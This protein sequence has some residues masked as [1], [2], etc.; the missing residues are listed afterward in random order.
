MIS[1]SLLGGRKV[2]YCDATLLAPEEVTTL[3][4]VRTLAQD[5][6]DN[7]HLVDSDFWRGRFVFFTNTI[8]FDHNTTYIVT[9]S[10]GVRPIDGNL[11]LS[12]DLSIDFTTAPKFKFTVS[13]TEHTIKLMFTQPLPE[14][15]LRDGLISMEVQD[16][17]FFPFG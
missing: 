10:S 16:S 11:P 12:H 2:K 6:M 9:F 4:A 7:S 17:H 15:A 1:V 8:P 5:A 14:H 3:H 13:E